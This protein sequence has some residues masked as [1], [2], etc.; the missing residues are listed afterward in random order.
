M[1]I[2]V[3][4]TGGSINAQVSSNF[5]RCPYFVI[6]DTDTKKYEIVSNPAVGVLG[7]AGPEAANLINNKGCKVILTGQVG[8]KAKVALEKLGIKIV[9]GISG[10][11]K[12]AVENYLKSLE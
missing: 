1:K 8:P 11:V 6:Y 3:S 7:G 2:A 4:S 5:G 12:D 9:T 10:M